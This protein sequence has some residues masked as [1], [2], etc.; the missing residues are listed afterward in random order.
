M[1][2][3]L[4]GDATQ[5]KAKGV[6]IIAHIC[7]DVGA[8][9][10]GFVL[11]L[12]KRWLQPELSYR[13]IRQ[14]D[15][16]LG[17]VQLVNVQQDE[18]DKSIY[19]ANM[20]AQHNVRPIVIDNVQVQPIRYGALAVCLKKLRDDAI[21]YEAS[22]HMPRIGSGLAGGDWLVIEKLINECLHDIDVYVYDLK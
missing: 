5:P 16:N 11:A 3:Y 19:V 13:R 21:Q 4:K 9:G 20:I 6:K 17:V 7:N 14:E 12:S 22:I 8:W 1:I 18:D 15:R 10:A 2:T